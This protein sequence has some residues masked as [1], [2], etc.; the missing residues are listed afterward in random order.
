MYDV[1]SAV[2][3]CVNTGLPAAGVSGVVAV[4]PPHWLFGAGWQPG[5]VG[6]TVARFVTKPVPVTTPLTVYVAT[7]P[8]GR[9]TEPAMLFPLEPA[10]SHVPA[11]VV[12][13]LTVTEPTVAGTLSASFAVPGPVPALVTVIV[14]VT[15][16][17]TM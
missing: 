17:P 13:Q 8:A 4:P 9:F 12:E 3:V 7:A 2:L 5:V 11:P 16:S 6:V 15:G 1:W 14:N 10:V